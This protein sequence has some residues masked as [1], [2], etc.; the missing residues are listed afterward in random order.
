M[1]ARWRKKGGWENL[2]E[3]G[4]LHPRKATKCLDLELYFQSQ[5]QNTCWSVHIPTQSVQCHCGFHICY[6]GRPLGGGDWLGVC[7][8]RTVLGRISNWEWMV[9]W[10]PRIKGCRGLWPLNG[11]PGLEIFDR[12]SLD[13]PQWQ[14]ESMD[15][16]CHRQAKLEV[17]ESRVSCLERKVCSTWVRQVYTTGIE[18]VPGVHFLQAW[19]N[20][21]DHPLNPQP[22]PIAELGPCYRLACINSRAEGLISSTTGCHCIWRQS[23]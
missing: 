22:S 4:H 12:W 15:T 8:L 20:L 2:D 11:G 6:R 7:S 19:F 9:A 14:W 18:T 21:A 16:E 3:E 5:I 1:V 23:L 10:H 17:K 13:G